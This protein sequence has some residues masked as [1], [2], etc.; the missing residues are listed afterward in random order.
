M[1]ASS[2]KQNFILNA[3]STVASVI[4]PLFVFAYVSH[5]LPPEARGKV[6][7]AASV[8]SYFTMVAM[9]G[10]P[11]YGIRI[12]AQLRDDK[13]RLSRAVQELL[14]IN[15]VMSVISYLVFLVPALLVPRLKEEPA[16]LFIHSALILFAFTGIDW[17]YRGLEQYRFLTV[18][19]LVFRVC[20]LLLVLL[21]VRVSADYIVYG[22]ITVIVPL[23]MNLVYL[24]RARRFVTF[25]PLGGYHFRE[26]L[27]K[28]LVFFAM[29]CAVSVYTHLDTTML[30]FLKT[31]TDVGYYTV[32]VQVK[33]LLVSVVTS[34]GAVLLPR[35]S[36]YV[37][38]NQMD[39]FR[40]LSAKGLHVAVLLAS[41]L[42]LYFML[43]AG[44]G[45]LFLSGEAYLPS[46]LP[47][48]V[49]MPTLLFIGLT[50]IL[51]IQ[52]LVPLGRERTAFWTVLAGA[53]TD[54]VL[55]LVWI[56][57]Y[58]ATGAAMG[59]LAAECVVLVLQAYALREVFLPAMR[60][61]PFGKVLLAL[62]LACAVSVPVK[63]LAAGVFW[64]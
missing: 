1:P 10:I 9:L 32:A 59:T 57:K 49:I 54:F 39:A 12:T 14:I 50:N 28:I 30:G 19:T 43:F 7:F 35:A 33:T 2:L 46:V 53:V 40:T 11:T 13:E 42:M 5:V 47:M 17:L 8:V 22:A 45:I 25:R 15:A 18:V 60:E 38:Q 27:N 52:M 48:R 37:E 51:G 64:K 61:I 4:F 44:E 36:W 3:I 6:A 29:V 16:L 26:H 58:A 24:V 21:F 62:S 23:C 63:L 31:D 55:N 56:P 34:L 20:N 41:P